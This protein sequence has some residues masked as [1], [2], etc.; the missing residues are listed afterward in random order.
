MFFKL[1][2]GN[3][4]SSTRERPQKGGK[5]TRSIRITSPQPGPSGEQT[6]RR[7]TSPQPGPSGEQTHRGRTSQPGRSGKQT[8]Q[9]V[10]GRVPSSDD[11]DSSDEEPE[12][13]DN[14]PPA[15]RP[16]APQQRRAAVHRR[17][18]PGTKALMEIRR[19][20]KSTVSQM[21]LKLFSAS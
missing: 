19:Y 1:Q 9:V 4:P 21:F 12:S 13:S 18:K 14:I 8:H 11:E 3:S 10:Q 15:Q 7:R 20:Q 5:S 17:R 16:P 6:R 2:E